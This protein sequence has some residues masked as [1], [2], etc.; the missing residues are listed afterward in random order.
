MDNWKC[1][2]CC[3]LVALTAGW[4]S[5]ADAGAS[6]VEDMRYFPNGMIVLLPI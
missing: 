5:S 3:W 6:N 4:L 1:Y 2:Y